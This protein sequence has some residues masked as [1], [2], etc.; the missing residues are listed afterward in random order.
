[1]DFLWKI[2][3]KKINF[4]YKS[5]SWQL[6]GFDYNPDIWFIFELDIN[7]RGW[8]SISEK[9]QENKKVYTYERSILHLVIF[10]TK[11]GI[12]KVKKVFEDISE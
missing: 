1:M 7:L 10:K 6:I 4:Y 5:D 11:F 2:F 9:I 8:G 12:R 3:C